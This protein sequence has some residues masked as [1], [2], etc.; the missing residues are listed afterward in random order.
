MVRG[1]PSVG[2]GVW[3]PRYCRSRG[4]G[5]GVRC[6][7]AAG[8]GVNPSFCYSPQPLLITVGR[9]VSVIPHPESWALAKAFSEPTV[10]EGG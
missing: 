9:S 1:V 7:S 8:G 5:P 4:R 6:L 2:L 3:G 10:R